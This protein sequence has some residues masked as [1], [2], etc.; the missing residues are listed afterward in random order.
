[1]SK[2]RVRVPGDADDAPHLV[3]GKNVIKV[4]NWILKGVEKANHGRPDLLQNFGA[5]THFTGPVTVPQ[6]VE[7]AGDHRFGEFD[8]NLRLVLWSVDDF[9]KQAMAAIEAKEGPVEAECR[10]D[11]T[12]TLVATDNLPRPVEWINAIEYAFRIVWVSDMVPGDL[13]AATNA[14]EVAKE[15]GRELAFYDVKPS[16]DGRLSWNSMR[17]VVL[18]ADEC[19]TDPSRFD[20]GQ[21]GIR[22]AQSAMDEGG[23][24][25]RGWQGQQGQSKNGR[26]PNRQLTPASSAMSGFGWPLHGPEALLEALPL[27][28]P[29]P[30]PRPGPPPGLEAPVPADAPGAQPPWPNPAAEGTRNWEAIVGDGRA[31]GMGFRSN[32]PPAPPSAAGVRGALWTIQ[33]GN[34][35]GAVLAAVPGSRDPWAPQAPDLSWRTRPWDTHREGNNQGDESTP[36]QDHAERVRDG[37]ARWSI[38]GPPYQS[39]LHR[40]NGGDWRWSHAPWQ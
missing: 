9:V 3:T 18:L 15:T 26:R 14:W 4:A 37:P 8:F 16:R 1:M 6:Y 27:Y 17:R 36:A 38:D 24:M 39:P 29:P 21:C 34:P 22:S 7:D 28:G 5:W 13:T 30:G 23:A 31:L 32:R 19:R 35:E 25:S 20:A 40:W 11:P 2:C 10:G 12:F 33:E